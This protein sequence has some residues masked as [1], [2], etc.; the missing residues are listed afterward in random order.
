MIS[1]VVAGKRGGCIQATYI[2]GY[3]SLFSRK[4]SSIK[5]SRHCLSSAPGDVWSEEMHSHNL[6]RLSMIIRN[7]QVYV[8]YD[9][10]SLFLNSVHKSSISSSKRP[11]PLDVILPKSYRKLFV[12]HSTL[13]ATPEERMRHLNI[14]SILALSARHSSRVCSSSN[15]LCCSIINV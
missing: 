12:H 8:L 7:F 14:C 10:R 11:F 5:L 1:A 13:I 6:P 15:P 4:L 3:K 9:W 2:Y